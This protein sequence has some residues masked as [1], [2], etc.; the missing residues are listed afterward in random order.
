MT[1]SELKGRLRYLKRSGYRK[2]RITGWYE[3]TLTV[4]GFNRSI[5]FSEIY[6]M[7]PGT[8]ESF[9]YMTELKELEVHKFLYREATGK[10][11][12]QEYE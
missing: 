9:Q 4:R 5:A 11:W 7:L 6:I 10:K 3:K 12:G 8:L 2:N 1:L